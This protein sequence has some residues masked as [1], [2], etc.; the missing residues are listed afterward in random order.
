MK[1]T[2]LLA[3]LLMGAL[4]VT[5]CN[6]NDPGPNASAS[7]AAD[8]Q[9][10]AQ[11]RPEAPP[12]EYLPS[13]FEEGV[14]G[15]AERRCV[16][17][18]RL[19]EET[20]RDGAIRSGE[21]V[22]GSFPHFIRSWTPHNENKLWFAPMHTERMQGLK[23]RAIPLAHLDEARLILYEDVAW[24]AEDAPPDSRKAID[25]RFYPGS[26]R[27]PEAG[28]WRLVAASGPDWGCFE[29]TLPDE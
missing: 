29:L 24:G 15:T 7:K 17:V 14:P 13:N 16:D 4:S 2:M 20:G 23:I 12:P 1:P 19:L 18:N 9:R 27:L 26:L 3:L 10:E 22:A 6:G 21:L 25:T 8:I 28:K 5:S 11:S